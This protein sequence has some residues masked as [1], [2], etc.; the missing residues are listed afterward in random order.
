VY[1]PVI[2]EPVAVR[3]TLH[4]RRAG[5]T[6]R[7]R[8]TGTVTPAEPGARVA[9]ERLSHRRYVPVAG[10]TI[11]KHRGGLHF[12]RLLH[13]RPGRYRAFVEVLGGALASGHSA[14]IAIR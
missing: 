13:L 11:N 9:F 6:G 1:S 14:P 2:T 4:V 8:L 12:N 10:A 7:M 3:V 5:R